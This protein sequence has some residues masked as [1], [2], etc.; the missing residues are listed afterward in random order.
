M[1]R[2]IAFIVAL[3]A[4]VPNIQ[5]GTIELRNGATIP[6]ELGGFEKEFLIWNADL[7][8][9]IKIIREDVKTMNTKSA[10]NLFVTGRGRLNNCV[11]SK[12][13]TDGSLVNCAEEEPFKVRMATL[14]VPAP[15]WESSGVISANLNI[16]RYNTDKDEYDIDGQISWRRYSRRH[17]L[18][19]ELDREIRDNSVVEDQLTLNY[20]ADFLRELGKYRYLR[21]SFEQDD[22]SA[23]RRTAF[24]GAGIGREQNLGNGVTARLQGG[25][26]IAWG[27]LADYSC[28]GDDRLCEDSYDRN[29]QL[30]TNAQWRLNWAT[31]WRE[32]VV[33]HRGEHKLGLSGGNEWRLDTQTGIRIPLKLGIVTDITFDYDVVSTALDRESDR[34]NKEWT[35]RF[36]YQW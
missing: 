21:A 9:E 12:T 32:V 31:T 19:I 10:L 23:A 4:I 26:D 29:T 14:S 24:G 3:L 20:Q 22:F 25:L 16:Q 7:I 15:D 2:G 6:G 27:E 30:A 28:V 11:V 17:N 35:I 34:E 33:F 5:A 36:G 8:G 13:E 1:N 18:M